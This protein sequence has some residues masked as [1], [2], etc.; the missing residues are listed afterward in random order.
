MAEPEAWRYARV[1][2][3]AEQHDCTALQ[4]IAKLSYQ[5]LQHRYLSS[6]RDKRL[7]YIIELKVRAG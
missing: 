6:E 3:I 7:M 2:R 5:G 1:E 4:I